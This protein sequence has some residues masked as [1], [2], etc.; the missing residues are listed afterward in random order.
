MLLL[1][2]ALYNIVPPIAFAIVVPLLF[3]AFHKSELLGPDLI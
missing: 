1:T 3:D 2:Q